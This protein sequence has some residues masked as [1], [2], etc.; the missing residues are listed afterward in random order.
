MGG[1]WFIKMGGGTNGR[2]IVYMGDEVLQP[3]FEV[4][5]RMGLTLPKVRT[6]SPL[7]LPQLQSSITEVKTPRL[8]V[9]FIPLE[10]FWSVDVDNGLAWAI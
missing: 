9:F 2:C 5:V 6:W 8:K 3:H 10:F 7:G 4:S 1:V